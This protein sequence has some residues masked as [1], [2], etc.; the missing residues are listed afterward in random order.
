VFYQYYIYIFKDLKRNDVNTAAR[1]KFTRLEL[2]WFICATIML[3]CHSS[4]RGRNIYTL[5]NLQMRDLTYMF[6]IRDDKP[7][8]EKVVM[9]ARM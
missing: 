5:L 8:E 2:T 1:G 6:Y 4:D 9:L 7:D 3:H